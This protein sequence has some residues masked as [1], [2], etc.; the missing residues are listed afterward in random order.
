[1]VFLNI[2]GRQFAFVIFLLFSLVSASCNQSTK[3]VDNERAVNT[4][5]T[6]S[7]TEA[8]KPIEASKNNQVV[9]ENFAYGPGQLAV[10]V[11]TKVT[12]LN[13]D[14]MQHSVTSDDKVFDSGLLK[15]NQEFSRTFDKPGTYPYHCTPHPSMK[16]AVVVK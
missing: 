6:N 10:P 12:W 16:A 4:A 9:I 5:T 2:D 15:Q 14:T 13:R 7:A 3:V 11:G 8:P 1:M